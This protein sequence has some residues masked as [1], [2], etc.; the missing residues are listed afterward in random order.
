ML[1]DI[2]GMVYDI[3]SRQ[4]VGSFRELNTMRYAVNWY[5]WEHLIEKPCCGGIMDTIVTS[6][7]STRVKPA[8]VAGKGCE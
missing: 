5:D 3:L 6:T 8:R 1:P 4:Y 2:P 7:N